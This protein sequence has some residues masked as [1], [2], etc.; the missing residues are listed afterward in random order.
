MNGEHPKPEPR[1]SNERVEEIELQRVYKLADH[2]YGESKRLQAELDRLSI[3]SRGNVWEEVR[4]LRRALERIRDFRIS[5]F[6][7]HEQDQADMKSI[8]RAALAM[9]QVETAGDDA[10]LCE[11]CDSQEPLRTAICLGC[12][13]KLAKEVIELR[14][15]VRPAV[16]PEEARRQRF[17]DGV[18]NET[19]RLTRLNASESPLEPDGMPVCVRNPTLHS[20]SVRGRIGSPLPEKLCENGCGLMWK[21]RL[22]ENGE[23]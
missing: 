4:A 5:A 18:L 11:Q 13:N 19:D 7:S 2:W 3:G 14:K 17:A 16:E 21:N 9:Q 23:S 20:W 8:A 1:S 12:W 6:R 10:L 22:S 15:Q